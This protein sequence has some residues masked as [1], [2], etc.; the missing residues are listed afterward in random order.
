MTPNG[1]ISDAID[2]TSCVLTDGTSYVAYSLTLPRRGTLQL[3][4][5]GFGRFCALFDPAGRQQAS[6]G[7]GHVHHP[8]F[9]SR[10][11]H[12]SG[13]YGA[14]QTIGQLHAHTRFHT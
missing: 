8:L 7:D 2:S 3:N 11:V 9:R 13:E 1:V 14:G 5:K 6:A 4:F 12:A 10:Q